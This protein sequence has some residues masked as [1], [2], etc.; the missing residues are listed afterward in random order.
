MSRRVMQHLGIPTHRLNATQTTIYGFNTNGT[1]PMGKIK[2][3]YQFGDLKSKVTCYVIYVDTSYSL[4]LR[5]LWI[6]CNAIVPSTLHQVIK[7][8]GGD[9]KVRTLI[10]ER[11]PFKGVKNY[12][13]DSLLYQD[14]LE[15]DENPHP[16]ELNSS[17][18]ED[19]EIEEDKCL[20]EIKPFVTSIGKLDSD[21]TT[22]VEGEWFINE[23]LG[24]AYFYVFASDS[25][26]SDTSTDVDSDP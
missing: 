2:L 18:E 4:L 10:A 13:T 9:E 22:G 6:H 20:W 24:L 23:D 7:Y 14:S 1:R 16:E 12:F 15:A 8:V 26:P 19:M 5:R 21:I 3:R 17:N 11:H 25:V